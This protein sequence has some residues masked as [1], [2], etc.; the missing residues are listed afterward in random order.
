MQCVDKIIDTIKD[1]D[2]NARTC[3]FQSLTTIAHFLKKRDVK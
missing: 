2:N 3:K 1:K